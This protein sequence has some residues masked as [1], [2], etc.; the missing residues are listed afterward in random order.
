[1]GFEREIVAVMGLRTAQR[2]RLCKDDDVVELN[3]EFKRELIKELLGLF[4]D[5][6]L[7]KLLRVIQ[8]NDYLLARFYEA[9]QNEF[10]FCLVQETSHEK[11][12]ETLP[13]KSILCRPESFVQNVKRARI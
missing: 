11:D 7:L 10:D 2:E 1:M 8:T 3:L 12:L 4:T 13:C 6:L 9:L 5:F